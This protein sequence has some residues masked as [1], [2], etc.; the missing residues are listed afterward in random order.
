MNPYTI[1]LDMD[2]VI[3]NMADILAIE[4]KKILSTQNLKSITQPL[5]PQENSHYMVLYKAVFM[6]I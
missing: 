2:G 5:V 4:T 3:V 6:R 1:Y